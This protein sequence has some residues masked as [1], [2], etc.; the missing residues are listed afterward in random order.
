M[1]W[2]PFSRSGAK[3]EA[4]CGQKRS[5]SHATSFYNV[6][7][8]SNIKSPDAADGRIFGILV[9]FKRQFPQ[10]DPGK[11]I[12]LLTSQRPWHVAARLVFITPTRDQQQ[13]PAIF[14][15]AGDVFHR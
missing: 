13:V 6:A 8:R 4:G 2:Q 11:V 14:D 1:N 7:A 9:I 12:Q 10:T 5:S 3:R 15:E